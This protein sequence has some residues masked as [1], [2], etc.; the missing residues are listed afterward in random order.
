MT[1]TT[2]KL[3]EIVYTNDSRLCRGV[4]SHASW[5]SGRQM[6]R[7]SSTLGER[8][9]VVVP[10]SARKPS[11]RGSKARTTNQGRY[12]WF[13]QADAHGFRRVFGR[14]LL[15][16]AL[17]CCPCSWPESR[18]RRSL[19]RP[20]SARRRWSAPRCDHIDATGVVKKHRE[21]LVTSRAALLLLPFL[22]PDSLLPSL[23]HRREPLRRG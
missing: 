23:Q 4:S 3:S 1:S 17:R 9:D 11:M 7:G 16:D 18:P 21:V 14:I 19:H 20:S 10:E 2:T 15:L 13:D 12:A 22:P 5:T 8:A 6:P